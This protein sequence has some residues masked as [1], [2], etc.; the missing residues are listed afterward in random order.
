MAEQVSKKAE[1]VLDLAKLFIKSGFEILLKVDEAQSNDGKIDSWE[2]LDIGGKAA[3]NAMQ[4]APMIKDIQET[5]LTLKEIGLGLKQIYQKLDSRDAANIF[6][7][8]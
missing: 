5:E 3:A 8:D 7:L 4:I 2:G 1:K 6:D